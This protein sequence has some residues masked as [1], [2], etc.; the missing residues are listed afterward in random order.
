MAKAIKH[1][2]A[3]LLNIEVIGNIPEDQARSRGRAARGKPTSPAQLFYNLKRSWR[4]LELLIAANFTG[5]DMVITF[6]FDDAHLPGSK[7]AAGDLFQKFLRKLRAAR[8]KRGAE[9]LCII[10]PEGFHEKRSNGFLSEDG[11]LEDRRFHLH[12]VLNGTGPGDL[13]EIRS[14][15]DFGGYIRAERLDVHYYQELAKYLTKEAREYGR[16]KPGERTWRATRNLKKYEV[17]YI[18]IP[19]DSVTLAPPIGA[20]DYTQFHETNPY[21]FSDCIG[22]RYLI[23]PV[24]E[25]PE[26]SYTQGRRTQR[27][28]NNF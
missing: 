19:S 25:R 5:R 27:P 28:P 1:I 13:D 24:R 21:G 14:L 6:T 4:E 20:V 18:E 23:Y 12:V 2:R 11:A 10:V 15:W 16:P 9:G 26:Y 7:K 8:R 22:A 3:G 17:E